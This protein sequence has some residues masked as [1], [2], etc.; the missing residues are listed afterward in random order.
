[1]IL[2]ATIDLGWINTWVRGLAEMQCNEFSNA[3]A[4]FKSLDAPGLLKGNTSVLVNLARCYK[5][6]CEDV[7]AL[8][9]FQRVTFVLISNILFN[10]IVLGFTK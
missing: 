10:F 6:M 1:M 5:Y 9:I 3:A 8:N 2:E 4:T 7:K